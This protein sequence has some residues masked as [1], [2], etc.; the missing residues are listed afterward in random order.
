MPH[1]DDSPYSQCGMEQPFIVGEGMSD[2]ECEH[3]ILDRLHHRIKHHPAGNSERGLSGD[4]I[5]QRVG[6]FYGGKRGTPHSVRGNL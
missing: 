1:W 4:I 6:E 2:A 3:A 5:G